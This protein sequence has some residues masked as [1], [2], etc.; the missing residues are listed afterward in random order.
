M[1]A[2]DETKPIE[3]MK[4]TTNIYFH[5][6][7][8]P[9]FLLLMAIMIFCCSMLIP[10]IESYKAHHTTAI[11]IIIA[12]S[13]FTFFTTIRSVKCFFRLLTGKPALILSENSLFDFQTGL[14]FNWTDIE[15]FS[16]AGYR[17]RSIS[18][19]LNDRQKYITALKNPYKKL[20]CR[21]LYSRLFPITFNVTLLKGSDSKI[22]ETLQK[23]LN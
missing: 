21:L 16:F 14:T 6:I 9:L 20:V 8:T 5:P 1:Q 11:I 4:T 2:S 23:Y 10:N 13:T 19:K 17:T 12:M 22:L 7:I 15:N 3:N 18:I